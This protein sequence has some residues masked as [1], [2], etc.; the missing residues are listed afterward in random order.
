MMWFIMFPESKNVVDSRGE[1]GSVRIFPSNIFCLTV[2]N[3][4]TKEHLVFLLL[5]GIENL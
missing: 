4:L 5:S 1:G 3:K 2:P